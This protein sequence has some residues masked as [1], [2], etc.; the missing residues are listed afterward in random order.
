MKSKKW[1][2]TLAV[3][4]VACALWASES[5]TRLRCRV[6]DSTKGLIAGAKLTLQGGTFTA[7]GNSNDEGE[8]LFVNVPPGRY[9]LTVEKEGFSASNLDAITLD[10]NE[11]R[12]LNVT[13]SPKERTEVVEVHGDQVSIVPEQTFLRGR[14]DPLRMKEL[15][16]NGRN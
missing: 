12:V 7:V 1:Y 8:Y 11:V 16:L 10:L 15:P 3:I 9:C 5:G 6:S 13:L 4:A 2:I 14:V